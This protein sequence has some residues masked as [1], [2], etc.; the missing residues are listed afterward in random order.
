MVHEAGVAG[1]AH[2]GKATEDTSLHL[3]PAFPEESE[4]R[5]VKG[6]SDA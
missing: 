4:E 2:N 5:E 1:K 3:T 6:W